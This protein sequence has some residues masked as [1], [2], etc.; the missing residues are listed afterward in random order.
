MIFL[1]GK[2]HDVDVGHQVLSEDEI[3][4]ARIENTD[5]KID[6]SE[7]EDDGTDQS[8]GPTHGEA[9]VTLEQLMTYFVK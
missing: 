2:N 7:D 5:T 9:T 6:S 8:T 4:N 3:E 1:N